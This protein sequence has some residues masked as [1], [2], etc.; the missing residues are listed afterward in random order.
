[1]AHGLPAHRS[2]YAT[3]SVFSANQSASHCKDFH[4][5]HDAIYRGCCVPNNDNT[6]NY[7]LMVHT[8]TKPSSKACHVDNAIIAMLQPAFSA[9]GSSRHSHRQRQATVCLPTWNSSSSWMY[10][11]WGFKDCQQASSS[12]VYFVLCDVS[13]LMRCCQTGECAVIAKARQCGPQQ[14]CEQVST[15]FSFSSWHASQAHHA[16][17]CIKPVSTQGRG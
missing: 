8:I 13:S 14:I 4:L 7:Q 10:H 12:L 11:V 17:V 1:M 9:S 2:P 5:L 16:Q 15:R 6:R 3:L